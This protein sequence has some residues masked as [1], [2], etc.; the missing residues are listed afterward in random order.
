M[1]SYRESSPVW[2]TQYS[3]RKSLFPIILLVAIVFLY[4]S[5]FR[6]SSLQSGAAPTPSLINTNSDYA[7]ATFLAE[8]DNES[9]P[10]PGPGEQDDV[11]LT[12]TRMLIYQLLHD[13]D[14]RTNTSIPFIVL[15]TP[16]LAA[17]KRT[18]LT[19]EGARVVE[20]PPI[21]TSW[22]Q[23][24]RARWKHVMSKLNVFHLTQFS[25]VLLLDSDIVVFKRLDGIFSE[26]ETTIQ[27]NR[28]VA[29]NA[30][31]DEGSQPTRYLMAADSS[32][33]GGD[34]HPYPA[35]RS[36][37]LNAGFV[38]IHPSEQ[39]LSHYLTV[40]S[41]EGRTPGTAP[42]NNLWEYIHRVDGNMP[43]TPIQTH[44]VMN[45]PVFGDVESGIAAVH[46]KWFRNSIVDKRLRDVLLRSRWRMDGYWSRD[47]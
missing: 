47:A 44:W 4:T 33:L 17:W 13:P 40:A 28:G 30:L 20:Y 10:R 22:M 38:V 18:L 45:H 31:P 16:G 9:D 37:I 29:E 32:P 1:A 6:S 43:F 19:A 5:D 34:N 14:T 42:E 21:T 41:I 26:P 39:V 46:E 27:E 25:K 24:G 35:P 36:G 8:T 7:F 12:S 23:P 3:L 11:Y 15:T 2:R